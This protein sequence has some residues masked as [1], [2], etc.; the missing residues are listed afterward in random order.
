MDNAANSLIVLD[1]ATGS[2][3]K[4]FTASDGIDNNIV[5]SPT[6]LLDPNGYIKFVY[7]AD[8]D[9]SLYKFD[10]RTVGEESTGYGEWG[11]KKIFQSSSSQPVYHRAE[12]GVVSER[13]RYIYFGTGNQE[14]PVSQVGAA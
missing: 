7:V 13:I 2:P 11:V 8:L 1:I 6:M 14:A 3:L 5:A 12:P 10:F 4:V 9:G